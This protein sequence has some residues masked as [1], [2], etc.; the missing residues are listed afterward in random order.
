MSM[1]RCRGSAAPRIPSDVALP[2]S[3]SRVRAHPAAIALATALALLP[4]AAGAAD[5]GRRAVPFVGCSSDGQMG[6]VRAGRA[7]K[8]GATAPA[9]AA[10]RLAYYGSASLGVLAPRGWQ[11]FGLYGSNGET[12]VVAPGPDLAKRFGIGTPPLAGPAVVI[13]HS[14]GDTSGR[15]KVAGL[16]AG[17]FP[18]AGAFVKRVEAEGMQIPAYGPTATDRVERRGDTV[19]IFETPAD[20]DGIGTLATPLAKGDRPI[21]GVAV[22]LPE[23]HDLVLVSA[24][25]PPE[26]QDLAAGLVEDAAGCAGYGNGT[27]KPAR[28]TCLRHAG[29]TA[30]AQ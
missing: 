10:P 6:V 18:S 30:A 26:L 11:C 28:F 17:L 25:L 15:F 12:L 9:A 3:K 2:R 13:S 14:L 22:L 4:L 24:R 23:P 16:A 7:P 20:Q 21:D 8:P 27:G 5:A 1:S 19:A 29:A